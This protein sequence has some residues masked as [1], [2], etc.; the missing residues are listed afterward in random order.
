MTISLYDATVAPFVQI[1]GGVAGCLD[2][3]LAHCREAGLETGELVEARLHPDMQPL[4]YQVRATVNQSLDAIEA[5]KK[6]EFQAPLH[7]LEPAEKVAFHP[8]GEAP[9]LDYAGLQALVA[10]ACAALQTFSAD[11]IDGLVGRDVLVG[12]RPMT[13]EG[14]LLSFAVPNFFFH[15]TT[16]YDILRIKGVPLHKG[17]FLGALRLKR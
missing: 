2:R 3:G 10:D 14:F 15:A 13:A 1:L 9:P 11:E 8:P 17:D 16:A 12:K 4:R 6:G 7:M 5:A